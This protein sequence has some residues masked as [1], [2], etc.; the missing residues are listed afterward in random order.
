LGFILIV[1]LLRQRQFVVRQRFQQLIVGLRRKKASSKDYQALVTAASEV[2]LRTRNASYSNRN[3]SGQEEF[4]LVEFSNTASFSRGFPKG[5]VVERGS[6]T[7]VHKIN[8]VKLLDWLH[9][10]GYSAYGARQ[11][12][13]QTTDF[14]RLEASIER[15]FTT[16]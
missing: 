4:V 15:M 10:N 7:N 5:Y 14:E 13:Q 6:T 1:Q 16:N 8:A 12:V 2:V 3:K 11:L 9:E